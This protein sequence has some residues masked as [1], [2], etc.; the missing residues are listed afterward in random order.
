MRKIWKRLKSLWPLGVLVTVAV[1]IAAVPGIFSTVNSTSGYLVNGSGGTSGYALCS[2]GTYYDVPCSVSGTGITALTGPVTASGTGSV[3]STITATGVTAASYTFAN[4]TVNA[5]GQV[6]AASNG[7]PVV[8]TQYNCLSV[9]CAGGSTYASGVTYT[10]GLSIPVEEEVTMTVT[11]S[12]TGYVATI[13][14]TIAGAA[15]PANGVYNNC[16]GVA[17][18]TFVV[19]AGATFSIASGTYSGSGGTPSISSWLEVKL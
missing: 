8:G 3:V 1:A 15:G 11:G 4:I 5:A 13:A 6:T 19:P 18:V 2:D 17:S 14:A 7:V 10:N 16:A 9:S 12:C